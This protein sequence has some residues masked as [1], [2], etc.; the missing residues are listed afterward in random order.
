MDRHGIEFGE[1]AE[2]IIH[3]LP[4]VPDHI[5]DDFFTGFQGGLTGPLNHGRRMG[6]DELIE[7]GG[8]FHQVGP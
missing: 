4:K 1:H 8:P 2:A 6:D 7:L 3:P 5:A